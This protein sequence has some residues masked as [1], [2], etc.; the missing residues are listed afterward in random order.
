M[1]KFLALL[2]ILAMIFTGTFAQLKKDGTP[3]KRF[4]P[5]RKVVVKPIP[6][7]KAGKPDMRFKMNKK[8]K[9]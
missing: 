8:P 4:K 7:T 5:N 9:Q 6:T 1:K 2:A 3:D